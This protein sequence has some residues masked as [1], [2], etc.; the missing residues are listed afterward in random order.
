[1]W[2]IFKKIYFDGICK[3]ILKLDFKMKFVECIDLNV[4][5]LL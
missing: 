4:G 3:E 5:K 2:N 1:M